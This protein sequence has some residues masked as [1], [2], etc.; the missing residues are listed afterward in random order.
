MI[1]AVVLTKNEEKNIKKCLKS[2]FFCDELIIIDDYST[3]KT[4]HIASKFTKNI[5]KHKLNNDFSKAR[6]YGLSKASSSWVLFIDA[7]EVVTPSLQKELKE[8]SERDDIE[9]VYIKRNDIFFTKVLHGGEWGGEYILRMGRKNKIGKWKNKV[10]EVW[11]PRVG[12][13]KYYTSHNILHHSH[14]D[15]A[16]FVTTIN[17]YSFLHALNKEKNNFSSSLIKIIFYPQIKFLNNIILKKGYKDAQHGF[18]YAVM[19]SFHS[20]LAWSTLWLSQKQKK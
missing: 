8:L 15:I 14:T 19:M 1:T 4:T 17:N 7:D 11:Q 5:F 18:I 6:N 2:I 10:H 9:A 13:K 12:M 20:F 3:D 16:N